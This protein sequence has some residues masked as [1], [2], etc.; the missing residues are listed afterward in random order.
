M[1]GENQDQLLLFEQY[2]SKQ[3]DSK[4]IKDFEQQLQKDPTFRESFRHFLKSK[5]LIYK[6][7]YQEEKAH[8]ESKREEMTHRHAQLQVAQQ[9][10][11]RR[12]RLMMM[13][14]VFVILV[15]TVFLLIPSSPSA[16]PEELFTAN[17]E[18]PEVPGF[19]S[20]DQDSLLREAYLS[21]DKK[22]F[23]D[24]KRQFEALDKNT[25]TPSDRSEI[26]LY[27]GITALEL[28]EYARAF[29]LFDRADQHQ[30]QAEWYEALS[31]LKQG[32]SQEAIQAFR[33][34]SAQD[35]HYKQDASKKVLEDLG[36]AE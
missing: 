12:R 4:A 27:E 13:A 7:G 3:L 14:A 17:Y 33:H 29:T 8:F 26:A 35:R 9:R 21:F 28:G 18:A 20:T 10:F 22:D 23:Q 15:A 36:Q 30:Q 2:I 25:F 34:I 19:L 24:A 11:M 31:W 16:T 32:N 1:N 6:A 5:E